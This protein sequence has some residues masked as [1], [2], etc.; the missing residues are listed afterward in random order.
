MD[1]HAFLLAFKLLYEEIKF[2]GLFVRL[3]AGN[4]ECK[5]RFRQ[6]TNLIYIYRHYQNCL[7]QS[8]IMVY[9]YFTHFQL[10]IKLSH[11]T[12]FSVLFLEKKK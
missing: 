6:Y 3:F 4:N 1:V 10:L 8:G 7:Q 11:C 2:G 9:I 5:Q 12:L